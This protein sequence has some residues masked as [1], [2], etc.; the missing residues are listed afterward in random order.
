MARRGRA[1]HRPGAKGHALCRIQL[2]RFGTIHTPREKALATGSHSSQRHLDLI[3]ELVDIGKNP[4]RAEATLS[5]PSPTA[6]VKNTTSSKLPGQRPLITV[7]KLS[8]PLRG[9]S[10]A[11]GKRR[12]CQG[13][14]M[15][16]LCHSPSYANNLTLSLSNDQWIGISF[17]ERCA[18]RAN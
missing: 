7:T 10:S 3:C 12:H 11:R 6:C 17:E 4:G 2:H 14:M 16:G 13:K 8:A 5:E 9:A 18:T 1:T 15:P